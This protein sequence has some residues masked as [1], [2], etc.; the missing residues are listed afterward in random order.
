MVLQRSHFSLFTLPQLLAIKT[1]SRICIP[2]SSHPLTHIAKWLRNCSPKRSQTN[3]INEVE[4][5]LIGFR[6]NPRACMLHARHVR[7]IDEKGRLWLSHSTAGAFREVSCPDV[8][9]SER[10][11]RRDIIYDLG[12]ITWCCYPTNVSFELGFSSLYPHVKGQFFAAYRGD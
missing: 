3:T 6:V 1:L 7:A 10:L 9:L 11:R 8:C 12:S 2:P 4:A 5:E